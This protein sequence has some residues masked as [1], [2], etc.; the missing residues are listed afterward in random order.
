MFWYIVICALMLYPL[1]L[2][3]AGKYTNRNTNKIGL[4]A[5]CFILWA[6]MALRGSDVGV[7]TKYYTHV[8]SQFREI[9]LL[10]VFSAKTYATESETW[11]MDFEPGYR[12][13]NKL[14]SCLSNSPQT[15]TIAN[16]T[17]IL[18]LLYRFIKNNSPDYLLSIWLYVTLG[19]YQTEMNVTRNAVAILLV[20]NALHYVTERR[21]LPYCLWCLVGASF[22]V[23]VLVFIPVYFLLQINKLSF[24]TC[25][26]AVI[27]FVAT[28]LLFSVLSPSLCA[29][30]PER[31]AKY[32]GSSGGKFEKIAVGG[33]NAGLVCCVY[34]F[35]KPQEREL[36]FQQC[37][38]GLI[39]VLL[40]LCAFGI[41]LGSGYAAR[42]AALF[43]PYV[44][45]FLPQMLALVRKPKRRMWLTVLVTALAAAQYVLRLNV[46]NIGGTI[47]YSFFWQ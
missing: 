43:G 30:L 37:H 35:M 39:L 31:F 44:M 20:Y 1:G 9:P 7:D 32:I 40:N 27:A 38:K 24:K 45:V 13:F 15:I 33:V 25:V 42:I 10:D 18:V 12:L 11:T 14:F 47:P 26:W 36:V 34:F 29:I 5:A 8:F 6:F 3:Y 16:S 22:H 23:S 41:S 21:F 28:G 2:V 17:L 4:L 19:T 46:N